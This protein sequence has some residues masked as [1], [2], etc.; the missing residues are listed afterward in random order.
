[1]INFLAAQSLSY[2]YLS[3]SRGTRNDFRRSRSRLRSPDQVK[4]IA[5]DKGQ[6]RFVWGAILCGQAPAVKRYAWLSIHPTH[7]RKRDQ[8]TSGWMPSSESATAGQRLRNHN[9][10]NIQRIKRT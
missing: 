3:A 1:M 6:R 10:R 7:K 9:G 2:K 8:G 4:E 5:P